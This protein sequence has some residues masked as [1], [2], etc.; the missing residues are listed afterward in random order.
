MEMKHEKPY[1]TNRSPVN[2]TK[3]G[4]NICTL[5]FVRWFS[6]LFITMSYIRFAREHYPT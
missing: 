2:S 6:Y 3:Y 4:E 5:T 1:L